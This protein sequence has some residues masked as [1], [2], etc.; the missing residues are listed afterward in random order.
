VLIAALVGGALM[1]VIGVLVALPI[2]AS[3]LLVIREVLVPRQDL[4]TS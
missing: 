1:G 3:I 4:K 2:T